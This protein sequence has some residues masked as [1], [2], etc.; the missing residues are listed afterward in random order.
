M[1]PYNKKTVVIAIGFYVKTKWVFSNALKKKI[2][3]V[4]QNTKKANNETIN[5]Q[6]K[7][8]INC[9]FN[10]ESKE[11]IFKANI[12]QYDREVLHDFFFVLSEP[13]PIFTLHTA[14]FH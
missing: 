10:S 6:K 14:Q 4:C 2:K 9:V 13:Q 11:N 5:W 12:I 3:N 7:N 1:N 8:S